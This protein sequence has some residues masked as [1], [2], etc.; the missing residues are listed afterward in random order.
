MTMTTNE[1]S[2]IFEKHAGN[3]LYLNEISGL[4]QAGEAK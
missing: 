4:K 1:L 2:L 3:S